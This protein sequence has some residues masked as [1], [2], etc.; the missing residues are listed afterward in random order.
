MVCDTDNDVVLLNVYDRSR[1][2][3]SLRAFDI[4]GQQWGPE[5]NPPDFDAVVY[6][7]MVNAAFYNGLAYFY[8]NGDSN[9]RDPFDEDPQLAGSMFVYRYG[10]PAMNPSRPRNLTTP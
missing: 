10:A 5:L 3:P 7:P 4:H 6:R 2:A 1:P 8:A 9:P